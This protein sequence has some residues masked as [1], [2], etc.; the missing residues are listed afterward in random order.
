MFKISFH[1]EDKTK[2]YWNFYFVKHWKS[3]AFWIQWFSACCFFFLILLKKISEREERSLNSFN[4]KFEVCVKML[5]KK[6]FKVS[7]WKKIFR[8][9]FFSSDFESEEIKTA[10]KRF[11]KHF[12]MPEREK[13]VTCSSDSFVVRRKKLWCFR[14]FG[15][16]LATACATAGLHLHF[17]EL[18]LFSFGFIG[19]R[20]IDRG[21]IQRYFS[22]SRRLNLNER[23]HLIFL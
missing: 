21:E 15:F 8:E 5:A 20:S 19:K 11:R 12:R 3:V 18:S 23:Q 1:P 22:N 13:L 9:I 14:L 4:V 10:T 6:K 17:V 2:M 7:H 16:V